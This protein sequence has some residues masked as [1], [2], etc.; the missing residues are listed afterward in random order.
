MHQTEKYSGAEIAAVCR[1]AAY[2]AME[3]DINILNVFFIC[4]YW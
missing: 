2:L 4:E 3:E 1:R